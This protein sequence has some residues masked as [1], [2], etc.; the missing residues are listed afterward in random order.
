VLVSRDIGPF[1]A[2]KH[3]TQLL[4]RTWGENL[5]GN[6]GISFV[7]SG[8]GAV[9]IL[10]GYGGG[11]VLLDRGEDFSAILLMLVSGMLLA[12]VMILGSALSGVYQAAVYYFAVIG[13]PPEG[14]DKDLIRD[15]FEQKSA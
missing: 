15:A 6:A 1:D 5:I 10:V 4:K 2:V 8:I 11:R 12:A 13:D 7:F 14:F 9:L 3:S